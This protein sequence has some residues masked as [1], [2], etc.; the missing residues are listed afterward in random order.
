LSVATVD[1][2][3][4]YDEFSFGHKTPY[5]VKDFL[6]YAK[7]SWKKTAQF[8]LL[9]GGATFDPRNYLGLG[10][11]DVVPTKLVDT[12]INETASDDWFGDFSGQGLPELAIGR[13]PA[14]TAAELAG[15]VSKVVSYDSSSPSQTVMLVSDR[16]DGFDYDAASASIR[17]LVPESLRVEEVHR[18]STDDGTARTQVLDAINRGMKLVNYAG[19]GSSTIWRGNLLTATD[20]SGL[21]N[22]SSLS[23]FVTMTCQNGF[24]V[25]PRLPSLAEAL[26]KAP[27]GAVAVWASSGMTSPNTQAMADQEVVRQLFNGGTIGQATARAK[28]AMPDMDVRRTWILF[29]DPSARMR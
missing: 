21:E 14:R 26:M 2:E 29:G 7:T 8:V 3:D 23:L 5:A 19:H 27:A 15:M 24:F 25:D 1:I 4:I 9:A 10:D 16:N 20:A 6:A 28:A 17:S 22:A 13:L 12:Q 18:S 11:Y